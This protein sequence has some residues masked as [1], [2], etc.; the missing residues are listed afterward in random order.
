MSRGIP[1]GVWLGDTSW[2]V[3]SMSETTD[4][5]VDEFLDDLAELLAIWKKNRDKNRT[6]FM[7]REAIIAVILKAQEADI[8]DSS[9]EI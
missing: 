6:P 4:I 1:A 3:S 7:L 8:I 5:P 9:D 2:S